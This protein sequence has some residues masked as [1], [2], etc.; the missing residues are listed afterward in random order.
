MNKSV[1]N[2]VALKEAVRLPHFTIWDLTIHLIIRS[3]V[4]E[5]L[6]LINTLS[7]GCPGVF[8]ENY[9]AQ[10]WLIL[11]FQLPISS[12]RLHGMKF[13]S[14]GSVGYLLSAL[15]IDVCQMALRGG[16]L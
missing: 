10:Q 11:E 4:L 9:E 1:W 16:V 8:G 6:D 3:T 2:L 14:V 12:F 7:K 5:S 13:N 15:K